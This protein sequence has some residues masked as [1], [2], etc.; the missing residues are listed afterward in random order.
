MSEQLNLPADHEQPSI[1]SGVMHGPYP[2]TEAHPWDQSN[3][4][5]EA[6]DDAL[7]TGRINSEQ[8]SALI[9][10]PI[11][12]SMVE[13]N[14]E[15]TRL[16]DEAY[17]KAEEKYHTNLVKTMDHIDALKENEARDKVTAYIEKNGKPKSYDY[18]VDRGMDPMDAL[19]ESLNDEAAAP[20]AEDLYR[21]EMEDEDTED[22]LAGDVE[23]T[24]GYYEPKPDAFEA[25]RLAVMRQHGDHTES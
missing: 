9:D 4:H 13:D 7:R 11:N 16:D 1:A 22:P 14:A 21:Q 24:G 17:D 20:D 10:G 6:V 23:P 25:Q 3:G 12:T 5:N 19:D 8:Y 2:Q 18:W 15:Q